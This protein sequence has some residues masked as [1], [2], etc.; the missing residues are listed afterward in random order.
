LVAAS[1]ERLNVH[2]LVGLRDYV[3]RWVSRCEEGW[4]ALWLISAAFDDKNV[5]C[6]HEM[7]MPPQRPVIRLAYFREVQSVH[8]LCPA[9]EVFA[10]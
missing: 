10:R 7:T 9:M 6:L 1:R 8:V 4:G 2:A 5:P 3:V